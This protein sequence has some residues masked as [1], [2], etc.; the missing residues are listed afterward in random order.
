MSSSFFTKENGMLKLN[1]LGVQQVTSTLYQISP[2]ISEQKFFEI[3]PADYMPLVTGVCA[4]M[5]QIG[6][7][8]TFLKSGGFEEGVQQNAANQTQLERIDATYNLIPQSIYTWAKKTEYSVIELEQSL[9]ANTMFS[10]IEARERA[11]VKEWQLGIQKT[12]FLGIQGAAGLLNSTAPYI[13]VSNLPKRLFSMTAAELNTFVGVMYGLYRT[14]C[15]YTAKPAIF[16]IP[17]TDYNGLCTF[18][19]ATYPL[20]TRFEVLEYAFKSLSGNPGFKILPNAY[21]DKANNGTS[22]N[23]YMLHSNDPTSL[24][25]NIPLAYTATAAGTVDGFTWTSAS[26]GQFTTPLFLRPLESYIFTNT[27]T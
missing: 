26:Y 24:I 20:K 12:A 1:S 23:I 10:L 8:Q 15:N 25:M 13:D 6:H 22:T 3:A 5:T 27:A 14:N 2:R 7:W 4:F 17:E 9:R 16:I 21:C 11:R 19:D 18:P